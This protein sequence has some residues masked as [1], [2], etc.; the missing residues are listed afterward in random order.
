MKA[1]DL[2]DIHNVEHW[3]EYTPDM[4]Q[5][6]EFAKEDANLILAGHKIQD[7]YIQFKMARASLMY[8]E[9]DNYGQLIAENDEFHLTFIRSKFLFDALAL[10]NYCIDLSWQVLYLYHGDAHFGVI[11][12]EDYYIQATA[13]CNLEN[14]QGRLVKIA[15][16]DGLFKY[17]N[18]FFISTPTSEIRSAYNYIKHRG[19]F[20]IEGLGLN[21]D[22]IPIDMAGYKLKM[23]N[24]KSINIEEWKQ[25][26]IQFDISFVKYFEDIIFTL[27]PKNFTGNSVSINSMIVTALE[28][29]DWEKKKL[30]ESNTNG[31]NNDR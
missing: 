8:L 5:Y 9:I 1:H 30:E 10:Y 29:G 11:Q 17:I 23:L 19:T 20:H 18:D 27:M 7:V 28:L 26:L 21:D 2:S 22:A 31:D 12:D 15:K 13:D 14:L 6:I 25:K 16:R 24:R 3:R 4:K